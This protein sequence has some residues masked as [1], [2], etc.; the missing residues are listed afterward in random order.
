M[1]NRMFRRL[2][3]TNIKKNKGTYIPYIIACTGCIAM[4]YIMLFIMANPGM[5]ATHGGSD[6]RMIMSM[7]ILVV[8][9]FSF[10][11]LLYSNSFLMKRRQ[12]ELGLYNILGM[13][14]GHISRMML[15]ETIMTSVLSMTLGLLAGILGSKLALLLLL[16]L[17]HIPAQFGFYVSGA[18]IVTCIISFGFI[19]IVILFNNLRRVHIS[20]PVE[21]LRGSNAGER[22]PRAKWLMALIGFICLGSG[23]YIAVTTESPLEA[24]PLFFLAVVLVMA[25]T[26]LVFTAGSIA[27]LKMLRWKKSFYYKMKNFTSISGMIY[28]MKQNA[29]GLASICILSTGVL[30]MLSSTVCLNFGIEDIMKTRYPHD[31]NIAI[32]HVTIEEGRTALDTVLSALEEEKISC[33]NMESEI[34]MDIAFVEED[35]RIV[36][37][38]PENMD[39]I[40]AG[41]LTVLTSEEYERITGKNPGLSEGQVLVYGETEGDVLHI[42]DSD[43]QV[44]ERLEQWPAGDPPVFYELAEAVIVTE[45]DFRKIDQLQRAAYGEY[46]STP[47]V[48]IGFDVSGSVEEQ[49]DCRERL[50]THIDAFLESGQISEE[51]WSFCETRGEGY[52]SYYSLNGGLLFLGI[53]LGGMFL[54]GT[55]L[56]IYYKQM[57]EGY[58]DRE[59]FGIMRKVGMSKR[60]VRSSIRRQILMVFFLPLLM[61]VVH[62]SMAF[63][64]VK[65]LL[66]LLG[67]MNTKLFILCTAGTILAFAVVYGV[68]YLLT[69]RSYY[70]ILEHAE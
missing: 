24:V 4:L 21:L 12:K 66:L 51:A 28:R 22:E 44:K 27:V 55:A 5:D 52:N 42:M 23:Y 64:M 2:A 41:S 8:G 59:R 29:V 38:Q 54:M 68:I 69:A 33:K 53:L 6:I 47:I 7:G 61:A 20:R 32:H 19:F 15:L 26:Y 50:Q 48:N 31:V 67:M 58:E 46:C 13:E 9:I 63:P 45:E 18:G 17:I 10:I 56:I 60:E 14:K 39:D 1:N 62:I 34:A 57:S 3:V 25:G 43:F 35:G 30:L 37:R 65:R 11:F 16:K 49:K 36:F 40:V 70:K